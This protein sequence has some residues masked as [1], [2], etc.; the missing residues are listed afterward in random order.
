MRRS[1]EL[2]GLLFAAEDYASESSL[3]SD[4]ELVRSIGSSHNG[5]TH[6]RTEPDI[7][8]R[9]LRRALDSIQGQVGIDL[10]EGVRG[11]G[12][13]L[14]PEAKQNKTWLVPLVAQYL[15]LI[16]AGKYH[17]A[18]EALVHTHGPASL[19]LLTLIQYAR[20][21]SR[22]LEFDYARSRQRGSE[23]RRV[24]VRTLRIRGSRILIGATDL[25]KRALRQFLL[26]RVCEPV[27]L[28][29]VIESDAPATGDNNLIRGS[30]SVFAG[31]E[32]KEVVLHFFGDVIHDVRREF[33]HTSQRMMER[34]GH[35]EVRL[36]LNNALEL[37]SFISRFMGS[38]EIVAPVEWRAE[39]ARR[40]NRARAI[41]EKKSKTVS[42]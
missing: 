2:A 3:I 35:L 42:S 11:R 28:G 15:G 1:L 22:V 39:Y 17:P 31:A 26:T 23:R 30:L 12:R 18:L 19:R 24:V 7:G 14:K 5:P 40:L 20:E 36:R 37:F 9:A 4:Y 41:H 6:G 27:Q 25:A 32:E 34:S 38:V 33:I 16:G 29:P 21:R 10:I 8:D 13:R